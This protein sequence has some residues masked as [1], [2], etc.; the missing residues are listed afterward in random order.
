IGDRLM[1]RP[2]VEEEKKTASGIIIPNMGKK[3]GE[4]PRGKVLEV[5]E[6]SLV[7]KGDTVYYHKHAGTEID[8]YLILR[9]DDILC[10]K[11]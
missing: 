9:I 8:K 6:K 11:V 4:T 7:K 1:V 2:I 3:E 10:L 5:G